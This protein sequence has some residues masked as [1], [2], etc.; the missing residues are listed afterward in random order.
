LPRLLSRHWGR[1]FEDRSS[2]CVWLKGGWKCS[3]REGVEILL[4][5]LA[6]VLILTST[7]R[8]VDG[9]IADPYSP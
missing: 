2:A 7:L 9:A 3:S 6:N 8:V 5:H 1:A 4:V